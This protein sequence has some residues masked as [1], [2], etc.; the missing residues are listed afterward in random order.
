MLYRR[1]TEKYFAEIALVVWGTQTVI[2]VNSVYA[3]AV[4]LANV[5]QTFVNVFLAVLSPVSWVT[6]TGKSTKLIST[7]VVATRIIVTL[8]DI[9]TQYIYQLLMF[10]LNWLI[11]MVIIY[12]LKWNL[13]DFTQI[14]YFKMESR[15]KHTVTKAGYLYPAP[16]ESSSFPRLP[17]KNVCRN[18]VGTAVWFITYLVS[19]VIRRPNIELRHDQ[20]TLIEFKKKTIKFNFCLWYFH[21]NL[22][23]RRYMAERFSIRL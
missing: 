7:A 1:L 15:Y 4:I 11:N 9:Y 12:G 19:V 17:W 10:E 18:V 20:R 3:C 14:Q 5:R 6:Y 2:L 21:K 13:L 22:R 16:L 23:R 8:I